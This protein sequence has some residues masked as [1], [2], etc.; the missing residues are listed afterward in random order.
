MLK[1]GRENKDPRDA[2][3]RHL[4][5]IYVKP[6]KQRALADVPAGLKIGRNARAVAEPIHDWKMYGFIFL[7]S[8]SQHFIIAVVKHKSLPAE[9]KMN[10][11]I[12]KTAAVILAALLLAIAVGYFSGTSVVVNGKQI[13]GAARYAAGYFALVILAA[14]LIIIIPSV[15]IVAAVLAVF[16][17][18]FMMLFFPLLPVVLL[19]S[20]GFIFAGVFYFIYK[21]VKKGK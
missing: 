5:L 1:S 3:G 9:A 7:S 8:C 18:I 14:A 21:L 6:Y 20:P 12:K 15:F 16:S 2:G 17:V 10:K 11:G 13:T 19:L 4:G